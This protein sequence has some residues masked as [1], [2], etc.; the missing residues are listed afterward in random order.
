MVILTERVLP[1]EDRFWSTKNQGES[2]ITN[3]EEIK[4]EIHKRGFLSTKEWGE[5]HGLTYN[6]VIKTLNGLQNYSEVLVA[7]EK[8]GFA[9][10]QKATRRTKVA[11]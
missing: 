2:M 4:R 8:D 7:L 5:T 1:Y 3:G 9:I 6:Y 11:A 10:K